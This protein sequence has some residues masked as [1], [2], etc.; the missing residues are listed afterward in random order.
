MDEPQ[1]PT[2]P[3]KPW[4]AVLLS[5]L[6]SGLGHLY[7]GEPWRGLAVYVGG[8][9]GAFGL[10]GIGLPR[11][12][13]GLLVFLLM[14]VSYFFW[15]LWDSARTAHRNRDYVLKPFNRWYWYVA[16]FLV[17]SFAVRLAG[18]RLFALSRVKTFKIPSGSMEPAIRIGDHLM[19]DMAAFR[20]TRPSRGDLAV[21]ISP[22]DPNV[23]LIKRV[24]GL[25]GE[26]IEIRHKAVY[27][28]GQRLEDPW[29][30]YRQDQPASGAPSEMPNR[31]NL[32]PVTIPDDA[33][34]LIGDDRDNSYD[35]R[36]YGPVRRSLL[37][38]RPLYVYWAP[39]RSRIGMSLR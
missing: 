35:S 30:H 11:T 21:F 36:F 26:R 38:G 5:V 32:A 39:D 6:A 19:A 23:Q 29:A 15:M 2:K 17:A 33:F 13:P 31:D 22:E 14:A 27:V 20:S 4:I 1:I 3:R 7:A 24:I 8:F 18:P 34:F 9:I 16:A 28:N 25:P 10:Y 37:E 12:F